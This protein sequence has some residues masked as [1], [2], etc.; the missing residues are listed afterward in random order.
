MPTRSEAIESICAFVSGDVLSPEFEQRLYRDP[1]IESLLS[2]EPA[3]SYCHTGTTLFHY[4]IGLDYSH[5]GD[6]LDAHDVLAKLLKH[7]G[8]AVSPSAEPAAE[9][10]LIVS[11]QPRWLD[12]DMSYLSTVL[13]SAPSL[14]PK[15]RKEWL[16]KRIL[17]LF[18]YRDKPPRW[19]QAPSWPIGPSGP[20]IF[21][22]QL[23]IDN[24]FHDNAAVYIFHDPS[25]GECKSIVQIV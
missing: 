24:Y 10:D 25:T 17:E 15:E 12:A 20:L 6:V 7:R 3:P 23:A 8:I 21:L 2:E 14:S 18:R 11:A 5:P 16:R 9:H 13:A 1:E 4:L 22:G 19:L